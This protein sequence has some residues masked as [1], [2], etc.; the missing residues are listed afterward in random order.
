MRI[1]ELISAAMVLRDDRPTWEWAGENVELF[2]PLS[3]RGRFDPQ[4]SRHFIAIFNALD[5]DRTREVNVVAPVRG[6]KSLIGDVWQMSCV[7]RKPGPFLSVYQTDPDAKMMWEDRTFKMLTGCPDTAR[8]MPV[9]KWK[10]DQFQFSNGQPCYTGGPALSNLSGRNAQYLRCEEVW[11]WDSGRLTDAETRVGDYLKQEASKI[12]RSSQGG[13]NEGRSLNDDEWYRA[14]SR[15]TAHEWEVECSHCG[16]FFEPVFSGTREDG[17]FWGIVWDHHKQENGDW[18]LAKCLPTVRFE[19]PH[20]AKPLLDCPNTKTNW[21]RTGRYRVVGEDSKRRVSFHWETVIDFPWDELAGLWLDAANAFTRGNIRPKLQFYQQRRA[22]FKDESSILRGGLHFRREAYEVVGDWKD[23]RARFL[24]IDRQQEDTYWW[25]VR[26]WGVGESRRLGFGKAF[27][28]TE[29]KDIAKRFK[30]K[31]RC[32]F[33]DSGHEAKGQFGV[34]AMCCRNGWLACKGDRAREYYVTT[35]Q[36]RRVARCFL[37]SWGKPAIPP[38]PGWVSKEAALLLFSKQHMNQ[39]TQE[40]IDSGTWKE[41]VSGESAEMEAV[42]NDQM[43]ARVKVV[44]PIRKTTSWHEGRDDHARDLANMQCLGAIVMNL[45]P[46]PVTQRG[47]KNED[48][49]QEM[50]QNVVNYQLK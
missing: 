2:P 8:L 43:A 21:N 36:G 7:L 18:D 33:I 41:P 29:L 45:L 5:D 48:E 38:A 23:E 20:C 32:V 13:S 44:D 34:Y 15:G 12:L 25:T 49:P 22:Q 14:Y 31:P 6:G 42:Y 40:M 37:S 35:K 1:G 30:V 10:W 39:M 9:G 50:Q 3:I 19:C 27:G 28:E 4:R 24:T 46:D 17:S 16:K 26:A 47:E 11:Q